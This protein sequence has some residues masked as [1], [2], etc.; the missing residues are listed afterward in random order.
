MP[1]HGRPLVFPQHHGRGEI[2]GVSAVNAS[3]DAQGSCDRSG[4]A[5]GIGHSVN[6]ML[7]CGSEIRAGREFVLTSLNLRLHHPVFPG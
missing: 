3:C 1:L 2:A 5:L 6:L 7:P 4:D